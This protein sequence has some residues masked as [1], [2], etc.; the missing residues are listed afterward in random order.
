MPRQSE[1]NATR[2]RRLR[3]AVVRVLYAVDVG[4]SEVDAAITGYKDS[5]A[6]GPVQEELD[7]WAR[8]IV[9]RR[10]ELDELIR[11]ASTNWRLERIGALERCLLRLGA[12]ELL[13]RPDIPARATINEA[14]EI[15]RRYGGEDSPAFV[16]GILDRVA[17]LLT[18]RRGEV[19][20]D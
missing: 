7:E 9:A 1:R 2:R 17:R 3:E 19:R 10:E 11:K 12:W 13:A 6:E 14:V 20:S 8:A 18:E 5:L 16:N 15:A 4:G